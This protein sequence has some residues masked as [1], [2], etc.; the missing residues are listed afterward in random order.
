MGDAVAVQKVR[1]DV[2]YHDHE[3][4]DLNVREVAKERGQKAQYDVVDYLPHA[5]LGG[6]D[7]V[8]GHEHGSEEEAAG[9]G[10]VER[11]HGVASVE[12]EREEECHPYVEEGLPPLD[13]FAHDEVYAAH[14]YGKLACLAY[15]SGD[16]GAEEE[17]QEGD[18]CGFAA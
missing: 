12:E 2:A 8:C 11:R 1:Y 18:L 5:A 15:A 9:E 16:A 7:I 17:V 4:H 6:C 10:E 13:D 14:D 3:G